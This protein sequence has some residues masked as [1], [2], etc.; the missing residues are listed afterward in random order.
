MVGGP[1]A[2]LTRDKRSDA[3]AQ[4][5]V[6]CSRCWGELPPAAP[7][8][9]FQSF[10]QD[11]AEG[12]NPGACTQQEQAHG[13]TVRGCPRRPIGHNGRQGKSGD[14]D[15]TEDTQQYQRTSIFSIMHRLDLSRTKAYL[16]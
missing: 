3:A 10:D 11:H 4:G 15:G 13:R 9:I 14:A 16:S 8:L 7:K 12:E 6:R 5:G 2:W 1:T